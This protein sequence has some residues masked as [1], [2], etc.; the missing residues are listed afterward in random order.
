MEIILMTLIM[1]TWVAVL[2]LEIRGHDLLED[3]LDELEE[4]EDEEC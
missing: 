3:I 2:A 4:R 1:L